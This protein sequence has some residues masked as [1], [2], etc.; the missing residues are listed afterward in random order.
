MAIFT[1]LVTA[2]KL[3]V[4][5]MIKKKLKQQAKK[6]IAGDKN[7]KKKLSKQGTKVE[8]RQTLLQSQQEKVAKM[9]ESP[10]YKPLNASKL[11]NTD[12]DKVTKTA[13]KTGK[14][15]YKV[16]TAKVDNI[17][18]MTDAL[19][20]LT[21]AQSEQKK[22]Q[23]KLLR[24]QKEIAKRKQK[25]K[26]LEK[27][28]GGLGDKIKQGVK[29]TAQGPLDA[30][31]KFFVSMALGTI[32][33][34]LLK[35]VDKIKEMF[36]LI[37]DNLN[38]FAKLLRVT[39]FAFQ[40]GMKLVKAG[41][42][43]AANGLKKVL[44]PIGKALKAIGS[45]IKNVFKSLGGKF[46]KLLKRIPGVKGLTNLIKGVGKTLTATKTVA[47]NVVKKTVN[48][49]KKPVTK[50][51]SKVKKPITKITSKVTS[52]V[53]EETSEKIAKKTSEKI[54][55][56]S[57]E[58]IAKKVTSNV[59]KK[60]ITKSPTRIL[61]KFFGKDTAKAIVQSPVVKMASKAA[62]GIRIPIIGPLIVAVTSILS[63]DKFEKTMFKTLGTAFG[64]MIGGGL[65]A[66][67]GG[68]GAPFGMLVGEIVGEFIGD[69]LYNMLRGDDD[70]TKGA[71]YLKKKFTQ[72]LTGAGNV[73]KSVMNFAM[74]MLGKFGNFFKDGFDK[75]IDDFPTVK[76]P[77][78]KVFGLP[79]GL[80]TS[81]GKVAE[82]LGLEKY[83][84]DGRV[85][86]IPDLSLLSPFGM[87]KLLPHLK[88]SF[89]PSGEKEEI[90]KNGGTSSS[91]GGEEKEE[92]T[93]AKVETSDNNERDALDDMLDQMREEDEDIQPTAA[94]LGDKDTSSTSSTVSDVSSK[95]TY[96]EIPPGTVIL[97]KPERSDFKGR[98]GAEQFKKAMIMY[99]NQKEVLNSYQEAHA[100]TELAK[101]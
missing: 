99:N 57:S 38:K 48:K 28:T 52:K 3:L 40:E 90:P 50:T 21:G 82:T 47:K 53:A 49:V 89:F 64:G 23:L 87:G 68:L 44:S 56:K 70:G 13:T 83:V 19:A 75:F 54:A 97:T 76:V 84:K 22:E 36:K 25:E 88:N 63:G 27:K 29:K 59:F 39:I 62:K 14:I 20:F 69:L 80:Q 7:K 33:M 72:V 24:Q 78:I 73:A 81:L 61:I 26:K 45:K 85:E 32:V 43:M 34:F 16:L 55:K 8:K 5:K 42:K 96:E 98:S 93:A 77:E 58:K 91:G 95:A 37:G 31:I 92:T 41:F 2:T 67:L 66:A 74:S 10:S 1:T 4:K 11:M 65:G 17:V 18:G 30:M 46:L 71:A 94:H 100:A 12:A 9:K 35:N 6:F 79:L 15:D 86:E 101:I 60:G 51:V